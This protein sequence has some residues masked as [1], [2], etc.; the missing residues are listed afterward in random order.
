MHNGELIYTYKPKKPIK[1]GTKFEWLT[2]IEEQKC[3]KNGKYVYIKVKCACKCGNIK[4]TDLRSLTSGHCSSCGCKPRK[5]KTR[6]RSTLINDN[7]KRCSKCMN[8]YGKDMFFKDIYNK[9]NLTVCCKKC[10]YIRD[11]NKRY[12]VLEDEINKIL[13]LYNM[14]CAICQSDLILFDKT[15][16]PIFDHNHITNKIRGILCRK[17][18]MALHQNITKLNI[19]NIIKYLNKL[20]YKFQNT[21]NDQPYFKFSKQ[22]I[23]NIKYNYKISK[24]NFYEMI[25]FSNGHCHTCNKKI[26]LTKDLHIDHCHRTEKVRGIVC[27]SCNYII[28]A[29]KD[30]TDLLNKA[31]YY[32]ENNYETSSESTN[33]TCS[34]LNPAKIL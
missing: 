6:N 14:S 18:N 17:C 12:G 7:K 28:A 25:N 5:P 29:F 23:Y 3:Y 16:G 8:T 19:E 32:L 24:Y 22:R 30:S 34:I 9:D 31:I 1:I 15:N 21:I 33:P 4:I 20:E 26:L 2:T 10:F 13:N 11:I 27:N